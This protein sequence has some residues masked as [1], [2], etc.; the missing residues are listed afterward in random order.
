MEDLIKINKELELEL[1]AAR[2]QLRANERELMQ[3]KL[4]NNSMTRILELLP[5]GIRIASLDD[6][7]LAYANKAFMDI[8]GCKDFE[9][10]VAGRSMFDFMPEIQ[11][12]GRKSVD[13]VNEFFMTDNAAMDFQCFK[14]DGDPF[15]A[16]IMSC[17]INY[18]G[19]QSNIAVIEDITEKKQAE[20]TLKH[21]AKLSN[22]KKEMDIAFL[23]KKEIFDDI[24]G[25]CLRQAADAVDLDG[26]DICRLVDT[27]EGQRFGQIYCW[28]QAEGRLTPI[29][30]NLRIMQRHPA[31]E[32]WDAEL[33]K[34]GVVNIHTGIMS[35]DEIA[36]LNPMNIKSLLLTPV[37]IDDE[38]WG[39]VAFQDLAGDRLFDDESII[40][41]SSVGRLCASAIIRNEIE[42]ELAG[43]EERMRLMLDS[44][45]ICCQ[46][47]DRNFRKIDCNQAAVQ[48]FGFNDKEEFLRRSNE[49][50]HEF[51]PDGQRS[52][53]K[54]QMLL[55]KTFD[56]GRCSSDWT[57]KLMDGT[58]MPAEVIL[59]RVGHG[60]SCSVAGY[61]R[62]LREHYS[63]MDEINKRTSEL[64]IHRNTLQGIIDSIPDLVFCKD[65]N[66]RYTL[67]NTACVDFFNSGMDFIIG[68]NDVELNFPDEVI[69]T[70]R[71]SDE[72]IYAG[73]NKV[74]YDSWIPSPDGLLRYYETS[75]A[76]IMQ[77][78][79]I[80]GLV[81]I[82]RDITEK[83]R[84]GQELETTLEQ[85][86][87][88]EQELIRAQE[89]NQL[90][91]SKLNLV[92]KATKIGLWEM[93]IANDDPTKP[94]NVFMWSNEFRHML[95]FSDETDF[96]NVLG[97]WSDRLHPEDKDKIL[98][99]AVQ[100]LL[101]KT[102]NTPYDTEYRLMKK[103]GE[104]GHFQA[105]GETLRDESGNAILISGAL[106]DITESKN[107]LFE[108]EK[109]RMQAEAANK[110]K[111]DFLSSMSH[112]IR[113]PMNAIL[114][115]T[116]IQLQNKALGGDVME[117]FDKIYAA[118]DL[119][120][121]IINDIL[122][123]SKIEAGKLELMIDTY[124]IASLI[125][126][127]A[128]LNMTRIGSK[129]IEF[130]LC[131]DENLPSRLVGDKL[132]ITQI[133]N[134]LL[135]N[136]FKYTEAGKVEFSIS[137]EA[138]DNDDTVVL[139]LR[140]SDTGY[141]MTQEQ[142][143]ILFDKF[144]RFTHDV[145]RVIEGTGLGMNIT[146]NLARM[147]N[148]RIFVESA[149]GKGSA[150]TVRLPQGR[151]GSDML[152]KEL[153]DSL[154]RI[155]TS[156]STQMT[157]TQIIRTP[158][159]YGRVLIVDDVETNIYVAKGLLSP[160]SL[161]IDSVSSGFEAIELIK[162]GNYYDI[163]FMDHMMPKM[164]GVETTKIIR[165]MG[166]EGSIVALTA[167]AVAG[168]ADMFLDNGFDDFVSKPIDIRQLN[169]ILNRMVRDKQ[170]PDVIAAAKRQADS[171]NERLVGNE[172]GIVIA[173]QL[174]EA[175][176]RDASKSIAV[177][178]SIN[179]KQDPLDDE[180]KR[181]YDTH[182][183][184]MKSALANIGKPE[185][186]AFA[187][188]LEQAAHDWQIELITSET[189]A[190]LDSL[191][192]IIEELAPQEKNIQTA[193]ENRSYLR[194]QLLVIKA[195]CVKYDERTAHDAATQLRQESWSQATQ[196]LLGA[197]SEYL[198]H[199]DFDEV[200]DAV[201]KF[202]E[203][204]QI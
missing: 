140:V 143:D 142:L 169:T 112:E 46:L 55:Q 165:S 28:S 104:Y 86:R 183:H 14:L 35:G 175:F 120:L 52:V 170:T 159:P 110:A 88:R 117:A 89:L 31:I 25:E 79:A 41:L 180:D 101:D 71:S 154:C 147:M 54:I 38:L 98:D 181:M 108:I 156:G 33:S 16:R 83:Y 168:Q 80:V 95:G 49:I 69:K 50:Y 17:N 152:E 82:S 178:G 114:G 67:F 119:L 187:S 48:L 90:Q 132:R 96:P 199:S 171:D 162:Q 2:Q 72:R 177:L 7:S 127:A 6:G 131:L 97:S 62:D 139:V 174:I 65:S 135:T 121:G 19:K 44:T 172:S 11:P 53:E 36:F 109:Q 179:T 8:F 13:M 68:K 160:Y 10:D 146:L 153:A 204:E 134:N 74:V 61:A 21:R 150:F 60:D 203:S 91:L 59:I 70:M 24:I 166:Y 51:Q 102:G 136:A 137:T 9:M 18:M 106:M 64:Q 190:F 22:A 63:L 107:M 103:N 15:T 148:G 182:V 151:S 93:E 129:P 133:L 76:P 81:G 99:H 161:N 185:L 4:S 77:G 149:P 130:E 85:S 184:G 186:S 45:P 202:I 100:H 5:F 12:D 141:G 189:P 32:K 34:G 124:E 94:E 155:Q 66:F 128:Q 3:Y 158:M 191:R 176:I 75:K 164:D 138:G 201:D 40:F 23:S 27:G 57:Y 105:Y 198:L 30:G 87:A 157:R 122:D 118:G 167:N 37:V 39:A 73:E 113:T 116:E 115:I 196:K 26:I 123:L 125:N 29:E 1:S 111:S 197:I 92:I 42:T 200:V 126:D 192:A 84:M 78:G 188:K 163:V 194:D 145:N 20:E 58:M 56:E 173:P 193:D 195:A 47:W 144:T 43:V